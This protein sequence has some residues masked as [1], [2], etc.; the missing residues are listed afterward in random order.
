LATTTLAITAVA[1]AGYIVGAHV[2]TGWGVDP[3]MAVNTAA[4]FLLVGLA[5]LLLTMEEE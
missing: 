2:L 1:I 4:C 5:L 3:G